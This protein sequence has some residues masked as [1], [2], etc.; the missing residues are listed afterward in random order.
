[1]C[2][3]SMGQQ[4]HPRKTKGSQSRLQFSS[5]REIKKLP[6]TASYQTD[7][8]CKRLFVFLY[9]CFSSPLFFFLDFPPVLWCVCFPAPPSQ[10]NASPVRAE[11]L[12]CSLRS[13]QPQKAGPTGALTPTPSQRA[14]EATFRAVMWTGVNRCHLL[15]INR[16]HGQNLHRQK[17]CYKNC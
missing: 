12:L 9:L 10:E 11:A 16:K 5:K 13:P 15:V 6:T 14:H 3:M 2:G 17:S 4:N 1:M 8:G 7:I